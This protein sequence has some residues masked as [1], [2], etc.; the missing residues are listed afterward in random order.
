MKFFLKKSQNN[1]IPGKLQGIEQSNR[2]AK[3]AT[4]E[5]ILT[6]PHYRDENFKFC[7]IFYT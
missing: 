4:P 6:E 2:E 3:L 1:F 5:S 7:E